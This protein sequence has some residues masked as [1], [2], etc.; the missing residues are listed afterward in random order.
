MSPADITALTDLDTVEVSLVDRGAN[1]KTFALAKNAPSETIVDKFDEILKAVLDTPVDGEDKFDE[2]A[3]AKKLS[4]K[5]AGAARGAMRILSAFREEMPED[6]MQALTKLCGYKEPEK[7]AAPAIVAATVAEVK[8]EPDMSKMPEE[9]RAQVE[10]LWK[11]NKEAVA[12]GEALQKSL[13]AERE[14]RVKKEWFEKSTSLG[15]LPGHK[16]E[17]IAE[18]LHSVAKGSPEMADAIAKVLADN[19]RVISKSKA[20]EEIGSSRAVSSGD[21]WSQIEKLADGIVMKSATPISK[22]EAIDRVLSTHK[23]L[24]TKY[25]SENPKQSQ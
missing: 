4:E 9:V 1:K 6:I 20:F 8:A 12:K 21:A 3:K 14:M 16:P 15:V 25:L 2:I 11:A 13:D 7:K 10:S 18:I 5:A 19:A 23:D 17:E 22:A 24:Y